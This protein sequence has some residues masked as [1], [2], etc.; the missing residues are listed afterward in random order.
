MSK[1]QI[2]III[3]SI[4]YTILMYCFFCFFFHS[5]NSNSWKQGHNK[6]CKG[7]QWKRRQRVQGTLEQPL[8]R[9]TVVRVEEGRIA[10]EKLKFFLIPLIRIT[11]QKLHNKFNQNSKKI[12]QNLSNPNITFPTTKCHL[13]N[14]RIDE[15]NFRVMIKKFNIFILIIILHENWLIII[16]NNN[17][18]KRK[19]VKQWKS[20]FKK[21]KT[22]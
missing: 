19:V 10:V 14:F 3:I 18:E 12:F 17:K 20:Q 5:S 7:R 9:A 21:L 2:L 1:E 13:I 6:N 22:N 4:L 15:S 8:R 16:E 11:M